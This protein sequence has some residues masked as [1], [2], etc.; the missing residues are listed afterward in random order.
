[1]VKL[2]GKCVT[3]FPEAFH[4]DFIVNVFTA[5]SDCCCLHTHPSASGT[6]AG[7]THAKNVLWS[8]FFFN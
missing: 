2:G 6:C 4:F 5:N 1:M 3:V 7:L 8:F